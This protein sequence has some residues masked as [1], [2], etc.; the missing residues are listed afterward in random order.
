M[1]EPS[2]AIGHALKALTVNETRIIRELSA[3]DRKRQELC[4][5]L[6]KTR[7][8]KITLDS[9]GNS[10]SSGT[11]EIL[12]KFCNYLGPNQVIREGELMK[13]AIDS[14]WHSTS[15]NRLQM[16]RQARSRGVKE[17]WIIKRGG[18][19]NFYTADKDLT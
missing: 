5:E 14:G 6:R 9:L 15:S 3:L 7:A 18:Q 4:K 1:N 19:G 8:A 13:F 11:V 10:A 2:E 12:R 16:L 17:G